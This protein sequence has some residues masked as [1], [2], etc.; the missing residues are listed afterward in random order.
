M[1]LFSSRRAFRSLA[2]LLFSSSLGA[3]PVQTDAGAVEGATDAADPAI[4]V[5]KG[6][7]F[8]A[9]P[10]GARRW[11]PPQPVEPWSGVRPATQFGPRAMQARLYSDMV[12]RDDGPAEDCLYLNVWTP[13]KNADERRPVMVWIYGGGFQAGAASEPRQDGA[14]LAGKGV[15][16]VSLNYRLGV[17]GFLAHPELTRES[18]REASGN[19]GLLDQIAALQ[20]VR[21]NI[22]AFGGDPDNVTIFGESAGSMSVSA[23]MT[24]PLARG[25]FHRAIGQSGAVQLT[26]GRHGREL[27]LAAAERR[28]LDLAAAAG[29][30]SLAG[31]RALPAAELLRVATQHPELALRPILD[32][33]V[34]PADPGKTWAGGA[35]A[36]VPLLA[37]WNADEVRVYQTFGDKRPTAAA[38]IAKT[39]AAFGPRADAVL[40]LYPAENDEQAARSAGDLAGDQFV[41]YST[42]KW[43]EQQLVTG[44]GVPVYR[45]SFDR[46]VPVVAGTVI[47]GRPATGADVGAAHASEIVYVFGTLAL[48]APQVPWQPEDFALSETMQTYWTNFAKTGNPNGAGVPAWPRYGRDDRYPV[49]H[50]DTTVRAAADA[51]RARYLF[52]SAD[53]AVPEN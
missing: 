52:W 10:V 48:A 31:L 22:A 51:H 9:P 21:R 26:G 35:Q 19:Y 5:F 50:L 32:G 28:G 16:V 40:T 3:A 33:Y 41:G 18:G 29:A 12:F 1:T 34:L 44:G 27:S 46:A 15:V 36:R 53:A 23:L 38:F 7:P 8:A 11:Q 25:L 6:I 14:H 49:Q 2:L 13:A 17:F 39:R 20:W 45:F 30:T 42:W 47:N 4:R 43:L 24:S 37:G